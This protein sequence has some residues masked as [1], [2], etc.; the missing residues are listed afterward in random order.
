[1][2]SLLAALLIAVTPALLQGQ[3]P[4]TD[5]GLGY[6]VPPL[7]ARAAALGGTGFGLFGGSFSSRNPAD[8]SLFSS[9][10]IG[11]TLAPEAV[12]L[13][14][15][16]GDKST[17]RSRYVVMQGVLPYREWTAGFNVNAELDQGWDFVIADTL[18]TAFGDY[19]Y[20]ERRQNDGGVSSIGVDV[21]RRLGPLAVGVEGSVLTGSLRQVMRRVF[22]PAVGDPSNEI[23]GATGDARWAFKGWRFR[24]GVTGQV[25]RRVVLSAAVTA[26]TKLEADKDTFGI[27]LP[28][29]K[30]DMPLE[31][32]GGGS[33]VL[34]EN[35]MVTVAGGWQ[36]WSGTNVLALGAESA[37]VTWV[38]GG[39]EYVGLRLLGL[40]TPLRA[41][42]R[43]TELPFY[44]RG[45]EQL[46]EQAF[47]FGLGVRLAGGRAAL[48]FAGEIGSRGNV[49]TTGTAED[50]QR[51]SL[52]VGI[53]T[54]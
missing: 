13:K 48:D 21:V 52:S 30:F 23:G 11:G 18:R 8:L 53:S 1:M 35:L 28:T 3:T 41:G 22:D 5:L 4:A 42:Y 6:P 33:A 37:D 46:T 38:G 15:S 10:A 39:A 25:G 34:T 40:P 2:R 9:P 54:Q 50:F 51:Y 24:G 7:D 20:E 19:P 36:G 31:L 32:A 45:F 49:E 47:T 17:G 27:Q 16:D 12:T 14:T 43:Y 44:A 26:Y 29:I